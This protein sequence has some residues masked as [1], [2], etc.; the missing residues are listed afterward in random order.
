MRAFPN[1]A[2]RRLPNPT[3]RRRRDTLANFKIAKTMIPALVFIVI[4]LNGFNNGLGLLQYTSRGN[5]NM[6]LL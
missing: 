3:R 6:A 4:L 1:L 5:H 2:R